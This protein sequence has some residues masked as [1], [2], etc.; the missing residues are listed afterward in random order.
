[1]TEASGNSI[2]TMQASLGVGS[3]PLQ[4]PHSSAGTITS[5]QVVIRATLVI[6]ANIIQVFF[7]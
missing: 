3:L 6:N 2:T 1:M 5:M 4:I 7:V